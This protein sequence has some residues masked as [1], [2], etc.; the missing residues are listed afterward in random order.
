MPDPQA[1]AD[2]ARSCTLLAASRRRWC[3]RL[4][5]SHHLA[6]DDGALRRASARMLARMH[7]GAAADFRCTQPNL[8]GLAVVERDGA[9]GRAASDD[10]RSAA[11]LQDELALP[12]ACR[13]PPAHTRGLPRGRSMPTCSATT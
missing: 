2:A 9:G 3:D 5:G 12:A 4:R 6:P 7:A 8:R 1:D 13:P 10:R 11:L